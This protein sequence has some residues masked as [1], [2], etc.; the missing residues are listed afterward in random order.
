MNLQNVVER[1]FDVSEQ[2]YDWRDCALYALG[3]GIGSDPLDEDELPYV[4]E[5]RAQAP[6]PSQCVVLGWP[7]LWHADP[8]TG[9]DWVRIL[10]GEMGFE[11]HRPL[12]L[13]ASIRATHGI[14]AV[15]DKGVGRGALIH[16]DTD[17]ADAHTG[18]ALASLRSTQ[19]LRG[20]GGCGSFGTAPPTPAALRDD[21]VPGVHVE[22]RTM[23]QAA[24]L[25]RLVSRDY[26][27]IHADPAVARSAGFERPIS[28][29]LNTMG[30]ACRAALKHFSPG[31][32]ERLRAM[33]VRFAQPA[34][35]G[36]TIRIEL[37]DEGDGLVRF[38]G[39]AVER[40]VVV[41]DRGECRFADR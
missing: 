1:R 10:H 5:E 40:K 33:F 20:D 8:A 30:L 27:P 14:R 9:I 17:I 16:F 11:L 32:P 38:R 2:R 22:Y 7:E 41:L 35:P 26:M 25:Y 4:Y 19:F 6:V 23:P 39:M 31:R 28:H 37:F 3:L 24:L 21:A 15:V 18:D 36:E 34:F 12:P 29:G 13:N